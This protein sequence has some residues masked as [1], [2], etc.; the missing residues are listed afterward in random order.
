MARTERFMV[1]GVNGLH[2]HE[3]KFSPMFDRGL[4]TATDG[5]RNHE[6]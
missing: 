2:T 4:R 1:S 5:Q 6:K 3:E